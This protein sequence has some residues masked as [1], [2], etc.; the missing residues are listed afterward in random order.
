MSDHI[1]DEPGE[2]WLVELRVSYPE[3][4]DGFVFTFQEAAKAALEL[5]RDEGSADTIWVVTD[6][7]TGEV[8]QLEQSS[9]EEVWIP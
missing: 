1:Y 9:F 2:R 5:T 3:R 8:R 6:R 7:L 4:L